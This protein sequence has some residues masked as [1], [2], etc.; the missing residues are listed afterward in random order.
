MGARFVNSY[1]W[2]LV[3]CNRVTF[4]PEAG[5][6]HAARLRPYRKLRHGW[7]GAGFHWELGLGVIAGLSFSVFLGVGCATSW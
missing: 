4:D 5:R 6:A 1:V 2:S 7:S 3:H